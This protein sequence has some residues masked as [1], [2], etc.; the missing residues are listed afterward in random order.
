[1]KG[2]VVKCLQFQLAKAG[3]ELSCMEGR[4]GNGCYRAVI[5]YQKA[6]GLA[7]DGSVGP[8]T[9]SYLAKE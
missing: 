5:A 9:R 7:V 1:M 8:A 2:E 3:C 6:R 4:S